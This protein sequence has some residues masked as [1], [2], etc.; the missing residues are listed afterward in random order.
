M[1]DKPNYT[2]EINNRQTLLDVQVDRFMAAVETVL[3]GESIFAAE[4]NIAVVDNAEIHE[5][6][7]K[8]LQHDFATDVITFPLNDSGDP[9]EGDI[10]VS[11]EMAI[12]MA[13]KYNW[14][15]SD[16][17]LLYIVHGALHLAGYDDIDS[18]DRETMRE[19]ESRYLKRLG[20]DTDHRHAAASDGDTTS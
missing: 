16:E 5:T 2:I 20:L 15:A 7:R 10:M 3:S 17:L 6:N 13:P 19:M 11:A 4:I 9:L 1:T 12:E 18:N 14:T 8:Y